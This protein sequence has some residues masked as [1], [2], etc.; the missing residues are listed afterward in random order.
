MLMP[1]LTSANQAASRFSASPAAFGRAGGLTG[2]WTDMAGW[3]GWAFHR[4]R[5]HAEEE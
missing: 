3:L 2:E 1:C 4:V 5:E